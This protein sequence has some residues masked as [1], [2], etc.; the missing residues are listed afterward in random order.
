MTFR[1]A[2]NLQD[3]GTASLVGYDGMVLEI[4]VN[5]SP[6]QDIVAAGGSFVTGGY[7]RT[8]SSDF[9]SPIAGRLAWSGLSGGTPASPGYI[10][11]TVNIPSSANGQLVRMKWRVV[12]D[13]NTNAAG[14]AGARID[15]IINTA[16]TATSAGVELSGRVTTPDGRGLRNAIVSVTD[17][18][19]RVRTV[20]TGSFG[21]YRLDNL[22][23]GATYIVSVGS[24]R[25]R[26]SARVVQTLDI[27]TDVDFIALE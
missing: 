14:D 17:S 26:F 2:F 22:N 15:T 19:G 5:G 12:T 10:T 21:Y 18:A 23:A 6:F 8:I 16:C 11:T 1:N 4:S 9:G 27:L 20:T 25:Y 24:R 7:N 3:E 13:N